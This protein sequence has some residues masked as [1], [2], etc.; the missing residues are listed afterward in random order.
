MVVAGFRSCGL[1]PL[2]PAANDWSRA[3][4]SRL[5]RGTSSPPPPA[6]SCDTPDVTQVQRILTVQEMSEQTEQVE[7][8]A[9]KQEAQA[10]SR[11]DGTAAVGR[12]HQPGSHFLY[13]ARRLPPQLQKK[14]GPWGCHQLQPFHCRSFNPLCPL[15]CLP[16]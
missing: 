1:Y 6:P 16:Q 7:D 12:L 14:S 3:M 9:A 15:L 2:D 4:P 13:T 11:R 8:H 10:L 5:R